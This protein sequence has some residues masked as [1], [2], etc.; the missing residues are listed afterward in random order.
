METLEA[1]LLLAND[2]VGTE[3]N[4][5]LTNTTTVDVL[6]G[7]FSHV[8]ENIVIGGER[9]STNAS[10]I[11][12]APTLPGLELVGSDTQALAGGRRKVNHLDLS[13]DTGGPSTIVFVDT[14]IDDH[15]SLI[16]QVF[17]EEQG[18]DS[19]Q[20][21]VLD[22]QRDGLDQISD[23]LGPAGQVSAVH[24][25][26]HGNEGLLALGSTRLGSDSLDE[27]ADQIRGWRE[28]LT[29]D[30]DILLYG[31]EVAAGEWGVEF[32]QHFAALSGADIAASADLTFTDTI[33]RFTGADV[34]TIMGAAGT[35]SATS[36]STL[37]LEK[38]GCSG[39]VWAPGD[40]RSSD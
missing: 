2:L 37:T 5:I 20:I 30:A 22:S 39:L 21:V 11:V 27:Y 35:A 25:F 24:I 29:S 8:D 38:N 32:V 36:S 9:L 31:C 18:A 14:G 1:R 26:S 12:M 19:L 17:I 15:Q 28:V 16:D 10:S 13:D 3:K 6:K 7:T 33:S 4:D 23:A 34:F 40:T